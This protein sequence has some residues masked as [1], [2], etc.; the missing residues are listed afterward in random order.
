[1]AVTVGGTS[2]TFND[3][4]VQS[5]AAGAVTTTAV[6]NA[7]AGSSVGAV[8]TYAFLFT[9]SQSSNPGALAPGSTVAGSTQRYANT[10]AAPNSYIPAGTWRCMGYTPSVPGENP[11]P[12]GAQ[13][14]MRY[15]TLFLRIS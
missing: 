8:G 10:A 13:W 15:P 12:Y 14:W 2:I 6:L 1:M 7:T 3:G 11:N 9:Q 5:T 4:T